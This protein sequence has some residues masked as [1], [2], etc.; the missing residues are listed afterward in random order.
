MTK[1]ISIFSA[2]SKGPQPPL[3]SATTEFLVGC[4]LSVL[5]ALIVAFVFTF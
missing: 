4:G 1:T 5:A 2:S 3:S